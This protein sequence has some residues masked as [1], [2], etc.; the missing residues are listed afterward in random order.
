MHR[1]CNSDALLNVLLLRPA[2]NKTKYL[3]LNLLFNSN[4]LNNSV[5]K[6]NMQ[7]DI[8]FQRNRHLT[9]K[10]TASTLS[11]GSY[12]SASRVTHFYLN[13]FVAEA[14]TYSVGTSPLYVIHI[15][16]AL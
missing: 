16:T 8:I 7:N 3:N 11:H 6:N 14:F 4:D 10:S 13:C 9:H 1:E 12:I 15:Y 5:K 2:S